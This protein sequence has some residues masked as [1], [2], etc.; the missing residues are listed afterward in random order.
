[1]ALA[2]T[3][4]HLP[5]PV[6]D[7]HAHYVSPDLVDEAARHGTR[8]GVAVSR[9]ADDNAVLKIADTPPLR[10]IFPDLCSL[11]RRLPM[12]A[13]QGI[14]RQVI[15]TWTDLAG[16]EL[17]RPEAARWSRLQNETLA[18]AARTL[19]DRF[20]PMGTLPMRYPDL[21]TAELEHIVRSLGMRS[22]E[23]GTNVNGRDLDA[24]EYRIVWR[25]L[26]E[27]DVF[28]LLHPPRAPVGIERGRDYFLNNLICY[29]T[30]T[31]MAAAR[32]LFSG[33][34]DDLP[35]LKLC[36]AHAGGF[37]P[38]QIGRLDRGFAAHPACQ[39]SI[40]RAPSEYL[41]RFFYNSLTHHPLA[42]EYLIKLVGAGNVVFGSDYPFEMLNSAGPERLNQLASLPPADRDFILGKNA[43]RLLR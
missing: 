32:L 42:L 6:I 33:I 16:D 27:L 21:A 28:V 3:A 7:I 38:Y 43:E 37:L 23:I 14:D 29:P 20:Q 11:T 24:S 8:Y 35:D 2:Q 15:S 19:P 22:V 40:T 18:Q 4:E 5:A 26:M 39:R 13:A 30:D 10:P 36:L 25:R 31:T 1:M 41:G 34:L 12:L 9:D 17:A